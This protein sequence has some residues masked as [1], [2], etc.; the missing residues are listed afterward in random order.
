ML[1]TACWDV[2]NEFVRAQTELDTHFQNTV[3][4]F[5]EMKSFM[6]E[7]DRAVCDELLRRAV[8]QYTA[9]RAK[10]THNI[11][12]AYDMVQIASK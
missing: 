2:Y 8:I 7:S 11:Q 1:A 4:R 5:D 3:A 12:M 9:E 6:T 10:L